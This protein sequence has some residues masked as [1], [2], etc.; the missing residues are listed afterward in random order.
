MK[1]HIESILLKLY[2]DDQNLVEYSKSWFGYCLTGEVGA[3]I[4]WWA[5]GPFIQNGKNINI[6]SFIEM[7]SIYCHKLN[8]D[9]YDKNYHKHHKQF[10]GLKNKRF[11]YVEEIDEKHMDL[12]KI[13]NHIDGK[14]IGS[15]EVLYSTIENMPIQFKLV[16]ATNKC[17]K[18]KADTD[19]L[20]RGLCMY[21]K[22]IFQND[23][24]YKL[25]KF[26]ETDEYRQELF[27]MYLP[28]AVKYYENGFSDKDFLLL[29][30]EWQEICCVNDVMQTFLDEN[31]I[32][33]GKKTDMVHKDD[34]L[35]KYKKSRGLINV[36]FTSLISDI[37][38][39]GLTYERE[40]MCNR[41]RGF[42]CGLVET[43]RNEEPKPS[44]IDFLGN[45]DDSISEKD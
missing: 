35:E 32:M 2:N 22:N 15:N 42:I 45:D 24:R 5:Y 36:D 9:A 4:S 7:Y 43:E 19:M 13:K 30:K 16:V 14:E 20:R 21:H 23:E 3:Q 12:S 1:K 27:R 25:M 8:S 18:F 6:E 40:K 44:E 31:Y 11:V 17:P 41:K 29:K 34:F 10:T 38:R 26:F 28:Y 37:K 33:T 39:L